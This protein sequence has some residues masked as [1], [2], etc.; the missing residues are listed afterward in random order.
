MERES[1]LPASMVAA[2]GSTVW[3]VENDG[4]P[5][6]ALEGG[7]RCWGRGLG[8]CVEIVERRCGREWEWAAEGEG[9]AGGKRSERGCRQR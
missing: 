4:G 9:E 5:L 6:V 1:Y 7:R 2:K 3:I 8:G